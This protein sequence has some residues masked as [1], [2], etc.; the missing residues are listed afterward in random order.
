MTGTELHAAE[1]L[2]AVLTALSRALAGAPEG[3]VVGL[4][5]TSMGE[6]GVLLDAHAVPVAPVIAWHD[7]RDLG[8]VAELG[9]AVGDEAFSARTGLPLRSQWSLTKHRWQVDNDPAAAEG[10]TRLNIAEWVVRCL[11]GDQASDASLASRTGWLDLAARDW[12][13]SPWTGR[14][15][16]R[17]CWR[18]CHVRHGPGPG[19]DSRRAWSGW[20]A[21]YSHSRPRP[22]GG[23]RRCARGRP[24]RPARLVRHRGGAGAYGACSLSCA[25]RGATG[26]VRHHGRLARPRRPVGVARRDGRRPRPQ[27][28]AVGR[29]A[30]V[31]S[32]LAQL[33]AA[34][35]DA[36]LGAVTVEVDDSRPRHAWAAS[37]TASRP[38]TSGG[39]R[40]RQ[41]PTR[42]WTSTAR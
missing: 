13:R 30:A 32:D 23:H 6:S 21:P 29:S 28:G 39:P 27:P 1:L 26:T 35:L 8:E 12:W 34:A 37:A 40:W 22:P 42:S 15:R 5:V 4:G 9:H 11:G 19:P 3:R 25:G 24:G 10:V 16:P 7:S 41:S 14:A 2:D 33:D 20:Q 38:V 31:E 18:R 36:S 17:A